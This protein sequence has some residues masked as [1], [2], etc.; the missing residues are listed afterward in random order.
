[1]SY[2]MSD[3]LQLVVSEGA[4]DLHMTSGCAPM[5]RLHGEK[6]AGLWELVRIAK[7]GDKQDPWILFK[8]RDEWARPLTD[9][10]V[11]SALPTGRTARFSSPL[12]VYDFRDDTLFLARD[13]CGVKPLFYSAADGIAFADPVRAAAEPATWGGVKSLYR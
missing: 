4:S 6:L 12:G 11:I 8:K 7:P 1:M 9:Y 13:P 2:S 5:F 3:L 10:D